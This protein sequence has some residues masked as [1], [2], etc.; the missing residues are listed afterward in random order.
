M[1][2]S[3]CRYPRLRQLRG[4][5][6]RL[7]AVAVVVALGACG[8]DSPTAPGDEVLSPTESQLPPATASLASD[9]VGT[10]G[11]L[12]R[13]VFMS[14]RKGAAELYKMDPQGT[15]VVRLTTTPDAEQGAAW[16]YDN[17][18]IATV[19]MRADGNTSHSDVYLVNADGSNG[20]W[21]RSTPFPYNL[22][23][24]SWSPDGSRLVLTVMVAGG[25]H[26]GW[27]DLATGQ[28]G[29]F[30]AVA[31]G[32]LGRSPSYD[33][34]GKKIVYVGDR[35][36]TI[37]QISADG[38]VHKVLISS[39]Q[40][41]GDPTFSP[42]GKKLAFTKEV[43]DRLSVADPN[44]EVFGKSFADGTTA[45]L[46][47]SPGFDLAPTWSPDGSRIA[48]TSKRSGQFQIWTMNAT[49]GALLRIT[50]TTTVEAYPAWSH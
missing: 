23:S 45:R 30:N 46:T 19:R 11:T 16:S 42:D 24:P 32:W 1:F 15:N 34:T 6:P 7:L 37:E 39:A 49:G 41:V 48:F 20:H 44:L 17:K 10:A 38:A 26:L 5:L 47:K 4:W 33:P 28:I 36:Y 35:G 3:I 13:I 29:L 18:R 12:Q 40:G 14:S 8:A 21:A 2:C 25:L 50:H 43:A 22:T 31:G 27:M 9:F